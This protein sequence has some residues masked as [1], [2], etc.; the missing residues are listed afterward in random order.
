MVDCAA[1]EMPCTVT[2]TEGLNPPSPLV[3]AVESSSYNVLVY[4]VVH[5]LVSAALQAGINAAMVAVEARGGDHISVRCGSVAETAGVRR[6]A[7]GHTVLYGRMTEREIGVR[8]SF[9]GGY[10]CPFFFPAHGP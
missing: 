5:Q 9:P 1:L 7:R 10:P 8:S 4:R 2:R 3:D 6:R